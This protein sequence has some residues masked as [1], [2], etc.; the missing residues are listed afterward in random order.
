V[1]LD[2]LDDFAAALREIRAQD[3]VPRHDQSKCI[4][5]YGIGNRSFYAPASGNIQGWIA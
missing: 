4:F 5:K 3:L 1:R 2:N